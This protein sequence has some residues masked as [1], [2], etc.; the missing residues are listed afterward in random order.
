MSALNNLP[1]GTIVKIN[2]NEK[3]FKLH[4]YKKNPIIKPNDYELTWYEDG[5]L[6]IGSIFN[7][8]V[9]LLNERII[10][11][12]RVH[13]EYQKGQFFDES[14]QIERIGF[15]NYISKIWILISEDGI[16]FDR[17]HNTLIKGDGTSHEDFFHGIEDVRIIKTNGQYMLIGCGK[18]LPPFQGQIGGKG[19]RIAIYST[20]DFF[21]I[22]Y[23]GIIGNIDVRNTVIFPESVSGKHYIL[24]RFGK[25]IHID[26]I[27]EG[28]NQLLHPTKYSSLW[29]Q[30]KNRRKKTK[31]LDVGCYPHEKEKIGPGP[32]PIRTEKGW[33]LIYHAVG[34]IDSSIARAYGLSQNIN[35]SYSICAAILDLHDPSK[36]LC[37]TKYPIYIPSK[38]WELYGND[39]YPV[40]IPAVV[41]PMGSIIKGNK[42]FLYSGAGD[43][44]IIL[45]SSHLDS[46]IEYLW[47]ECRLSKL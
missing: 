42:I 26:V 2:D 36:V 20:L 14:L 11:S 43:K 41:F 35:R 1:D 34:E 27:E 5:R 18:I 8:G 6:L 15:K 32:P 30:V 9:N 12:P 29:D 21:D 31:L 45:L 16:N 23:H 10:L 38:P 22:R 7:A 17:Y 44:Y 13:A 46:L 39:V 3:I 37:R 4:S 47:S 33:L 19:D 24:L 28:M 40:D 25:N